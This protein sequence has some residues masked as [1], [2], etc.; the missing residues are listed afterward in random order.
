MRW[1][2]DAVGLV[3]WRR[4]PSP[5]NDQPSAV[6]FLK[7]AYKIDPTLT[8]SNRNRRRFTING[9]AALGQIERHPRDLYL[10][11]AVTNRYLSA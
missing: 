1:K 11:V 6:E 4:E 7:Q 2:D 10:R 9:K 8:R 3:R 5:L